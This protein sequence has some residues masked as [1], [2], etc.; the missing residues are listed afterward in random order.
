MESKCVRVSAV[1][2]PTYDQ[3]GFIGYHEERERECTLAWRWMWR[4]WWDRYAERC[5]ACDGSG[6]A[7]GSDACAYCYGRGE[8]MPYYLLDSEPAPSPLCTFD[9]GDCLTP[10]DILAQD[11]AALAR[12]MRRVYNVIKTECAIDDECEDQDR[13]W[14]DATSGT[15]RRGAPL[16]PPAV[17]D[18]P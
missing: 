16:G 5:H 8:V 1:C 6:G 11:L 14:E 15:L 17:A 2:N 10:A 7:D 4:P 3:S 9:G 13:E 18:G 12:E